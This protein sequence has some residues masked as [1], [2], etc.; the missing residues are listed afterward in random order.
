MIVQEQ[1][2]A[3]VME[4]RAKLY[5][6]LSHCIP[7]SVVMKVRRAYLLYPICCSG[8]KAR[9]QTIADRVVEQVDE[10]LKADVMH[11]AA[12]YEARMRVGNKK[13]FHLE[14]WVVKVMSLYKVRPFFLSIASS[15]RLTTS[16]TCR[17][18]SSTASTWRLTLTTDRGCPLAPA[19][20]SAVVRT[21]SLFGFGHAV[22]FLLWYMLYSS[23]R[24]ITPPSTGKHYSTGGRRHGGGERVYSIS[25][26]KRRLSVI[27]LSS[28]V[29]FGIAII[30]GPCHNNSGRREHQV[31]RAAQYPT[32]RAFPPCTR[33]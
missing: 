1:S 19:S 15:P 11:W 32:P 17:S 25:I 7:P 10:A 6:L 26:G 31:S 4:V 14:A 12:V 33:D 5:E 28:A 24:V 27:R 22:V 23:L 29:V 9:R 16:K 13:I 2:P 3:R 18:T 8:T 30:S 20:R 21:R